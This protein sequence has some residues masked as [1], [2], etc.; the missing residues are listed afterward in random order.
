MKSRRYRS[1]RESPLIPASKNGLMLVSRN[2]MFNIVLSQDVRRKERGQGDGKEKRGEHRDHHRDREGSKERARDPAEEGKRDMNHNRARC[3]ANDGRASIS[4]ATG[5]R[6]VKPERSWRSSVPG[7]GKGPAGNMFSITTM[8]SS[9]ISP[10]A[11]AIP[12]NVMIL[13]VM[14]A[15]GVQ[16]EE[17][18]GDRG[19][20]DKSMTTMVTRQLRRKPGGQPWREGCHGNDMFRCSDG[21]SQMKSPWL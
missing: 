3:R 5:A 2:F 20:D 11:A 16:T 4:E 1:N 10:T 7:A 21:R 15:T 19:R 18:R 17:C 9:M 14:P 13:I 6:P 12:P 8:E